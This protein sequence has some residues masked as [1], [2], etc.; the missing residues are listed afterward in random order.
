MDSARVPESPRDATLLLNSAVNFLLFFIGC[1]LL[2]A[3]NHFCPTFPDRLNSE[4][5]ERYN[6]CFHHNPRPDLSIFG[7]G[8]F[9]FVLSMITL[10]H[11]KEEYILSYLDEFVRV[12]KPHGVLYFQLPD[13]INR[14][15]SYN[16]LNPGTEPEME[17][18]G[19]SR[20]KIIDQ[21]ESQGI[22]V[23]AVIE[24]DCCGLDIRSFRYIGTKQAANKAFVW[25]CE[26]LRA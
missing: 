18:H 16:T 1:F 15:A 8:H 24:D 5:Y 12:L 7:D 20:S 25:N 2:L 26:P 13:Q 3:A 17:M 19:I 6:C 14:S 4:K 10:Q 23:Q 9:D 21:L 11:M 22:R